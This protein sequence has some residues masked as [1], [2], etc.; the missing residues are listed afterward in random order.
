MKYLFST[1][2]NRCAVLVYKLVA[3]IGVDMS[4]FGAVN[5]KGHLVLV[6]SHI[7]M[8]HSWLSTQGLSER[9]R[10]DRETSQWAALT[11]F[12]GG[13]KGQFASRTSQPFY[14]SSSSRE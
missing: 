11:N 10:A 13:L 2:K 5:I 9:S 14:G 8:V 6:N 4:H 7:F 1:D 12:P 3:A